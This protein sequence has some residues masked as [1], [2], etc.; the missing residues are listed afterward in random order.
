LVTISI[1]FFPKFLDVVKIEA[2]V[3]LS[4]LSEIFTK[5]NSSCLFFPGVVQENKSGFL[6]QC[7]T[8]CYLFT[9]V[10]LRHS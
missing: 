6:T 2:L 7:I 1:S 8:L 10:Q 5:F 3:S 9:L 4:I